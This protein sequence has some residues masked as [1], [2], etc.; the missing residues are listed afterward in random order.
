MSLWTLCGTKQ[1]IFSRV[2]KELLNQQLFKWS[3]VSLST[4]P[5]PS[6][7]TW[8]RTHWAW[9]ESSPS[10]MDSEQIKLV[11]VGRTE[12]DQVLEHG[13]LAPVSVLQLPDDVLLPGLRGPAAASRSQNPA[14]ALR[15]PGCICH[16]GLVGHDARSPGW[17]MPFP[18]GQTLTERR[19]V[20]DSSETTLQL[21][22]PPPC[23]FFCGT[24]PV[25]FVSSSSSFV[26]FLK[27]FLPAYVTQAGGGAGGSRC[28]LPASQPITATSVLPVWLEKEKQTNTPCGTPGDV[29][30]TN[31]T[32]YFYWCDVMLDG[33]LLKTLNI[34]F[35]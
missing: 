29:I 35:F 7:L 18:R 4:G 3:L 13:V 1:L 21:S 22:G 30:K 24:E 34:V 32:F 2:S 17:F 23:L 5:V 19:D 26:F 33:D 28:Q 16:D 12:A 10:I 27:F 14:A 6:Y 25:L 20:T 31:D 11:L 9:P 8:F 15:H